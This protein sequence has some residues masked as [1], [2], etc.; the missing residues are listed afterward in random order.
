MADFAVASNDDRL[1]P[2]SQDVG[3][4][5]QTD[6]GKVNSPYLVAK[7]AT[8]QTGNICAAQASG[9]D[10]QFANATYDMTPYG[11]GYTGLSGRYYSNAC[12]SDKG[13]DRDRIVPLV[14]TINGNGAT[15]KVGDKNGVA[16]DIKEYTDD[17]YKLTG[18]GALFG[19]VTYASTNVG[20]QY[21]HRSSC[22]G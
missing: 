12:A 3:A 10:L 4:L 6:G 22:H 18:V 9:M 1:S 11:T 7:Y 2:G 19:T 13:A 20:G 14:A 5:D 16:Y 21:R 8:W 17:D 15:I